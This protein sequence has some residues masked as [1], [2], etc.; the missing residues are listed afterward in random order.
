[1]K[2]INDFVYVKY[3]STYGYQSTQFVLKKIKS[4]HSVLKG[5]P[6]ELAIK[7]K[8]VIIVKVIEK[9]KPPANVRCSSRQSID[10]LIKF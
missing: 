10:N 3:R 1:M 9:N 7:T 4:S 8:K 2:Q 6:L 5:I